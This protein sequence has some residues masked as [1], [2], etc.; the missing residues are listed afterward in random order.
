[1]QGAGCM[2]QCVE[3]RVSGVEDRAREREASEGVKEREQDSVQAR[4]RAVQ[5]ER[6]RKRE[7]A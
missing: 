1:M 2:V 6:A 5:S 3:F 7:G 4:E